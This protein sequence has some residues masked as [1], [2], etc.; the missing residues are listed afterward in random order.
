LS[1]RV[2][3]PLRLRRGSPHRGAPSVAGSW[4]RSGSATRLPRRRYRIPGARHRDRRRTEA[5]GQGTRPRPMPIPTAVLAHPRRAR[6]S[7][8][9]LQLLLYDG[10]DRRPHA[11]AD[12]VL[13]R[14]GPECLLFP[15]PGFLLSLPMASSSG[16]RCQT[17]AVVGQLRRMTT[18]SLHFSTRRPTLPMPASGSRQP[19]LRTLGL[20]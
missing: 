12:H 2:F 20:R 18:P 5:C 10:L 14:V 7:Q 9:R 17:G 13:D 15:P 16:T 4:A 11:M 3:P 1:R 8:R 6:C 19:F